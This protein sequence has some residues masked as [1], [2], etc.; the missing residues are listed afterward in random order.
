MSV[1]DDQ[2]LSL[3]E[4]NEQ[5]KLAALDLAGKI[6]RVV[7]D[8]RFLKEVPDPEVRYRVVSA[9][10]K[11]FAQA[12]PVILRYLARDLKYSHRAFKKFLE[13]LQKDPGKGMDGF[14]EN[15]AQYAKILYLDLHKG[16]HPNMRIANELYRSE[17]EAMSRW[18]K[19][20]L[21]EEQSARNEFEEEEAENMEK[22]RKE[23]LDFININE[24]SEIEPLDSFHEDMERLK[25]G[26]PL[27]NPKPTFHDINPEVLNKEELAMTLREMIN[28]EKELLELL[29]VRN[30][31]I[32]YLE[33]LTEQDKEKIKAE[34]RAQ[35]EKARCKPRKGPPKIDMEW[36]EGTSAAPKRGGKSTKGRRKR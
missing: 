6:Y 15:Q 34:A 36:L 11:N 20:I 24:E 2:K 9:K 30:D 12:Y 17:R 25:Y 10:Y 7:T 33:S 29:D 26:L 27:K 14:I 21:E 18:H 4:Q 35:A 32:E 22:K 23:L 28:Y 3:A 19:K 13:K 16:H 8:E 1:T 5:N 31:Q